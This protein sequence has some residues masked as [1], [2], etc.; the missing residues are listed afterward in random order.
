MAIPPE[1]GYPRLIRFVTSNG[2]LVGFAL[3]A[4]CAV[5][6]YNAAYYIFVPVTGVWLDYQDSQQNSAVISSLDPGGPGEQA[7]LAGGG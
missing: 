4:I 5:V 6:F 7:G 2:F 1:P 3:L